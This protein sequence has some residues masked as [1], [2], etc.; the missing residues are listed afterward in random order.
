V[1]S[2]L[3]ST[4]LPAWADTAR[5]Q[6]APVTLEGGGLVNLPRAT[7]P[8]LFT[9]PSSLSFGDLNVSR[10][11]DSKALLVRITDAGG[12]GGTWS[13]ALA[14]QATSAGAA[15][16]VA[17]AIVVPPGG[18]ADLVAV[19][20]GSA[21]AT[22]GEDYGFILLRRGELTR[23]IPYEFFVGRPQVALMQPVQLRKF[24]LGDTINGQNRV[25]SYCCPAA[26]FGP[27]PDYTGPT[28]NETG[29]ET[30]YVTS[31][32]RPVA[33]L[34]V[35]VEAA[36]AGSLIDPWFLGSPNER[37]VQGYA[38]TPVNVNELM[39][40]FGVDIGSA[41][42]SFPKVQR[43]YVSVDS[44]S[45]PFTHAR[46]P[47]S[48]VLRSWVNDVRPPTLRLL[49]QRVAA[50]RPTIVARA[51]D[52]GA[53]VDPLS[54][55][56][57]YRGVLVGAA[58]YDPL[59][60]IA[61]FPLPSQAAAIKNGRTRAVLSASDFQE[62]KNVNTVGN[63]VLPNTAFRTVRITAVSGPA[64]TWVTPAA[65]ACVGK[66]AGFVVAASST[67]RI[68]SVRFFVEGKRVAVDRSGGSGLFSA[69]W[70][71]RRAAAGGHDLRAV[72]TDSGGRTAAAT[73]HIRV[74]R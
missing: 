27:P 70:S 17:P 68:T 50:G 64:L 30:L 18:E 20:R 51:V 15:L 1:K 7:S 58:L 49:T 22:V 23:K 33:N 12:G 69:T 28:M 14:P 57:A 24:Q 39:Y 3:V 43:F 32:D 36:S 9:E 8:R 41:G 59:S 46:F 65:N 48:Y 53:G 4:A 42:A 62:S 37:D 5:I 26:P 72:A 66:T 55:V 6:E 35:A 16:D 25:T 44:G 74:C 52:S 13:V 11:S 56:I 61:V 67:K 63:N 45:D 54:L 60:G 10:G 73:R 47:G 34:G 71:T 38:G 2:A 40:D 29:T 21:A 31:I 19:A